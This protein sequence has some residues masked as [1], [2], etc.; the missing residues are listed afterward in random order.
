MKMQLA[1][2]LLLLAPLPAAA[3]PFAD[4]L[5]DE[6]LS[7]LRGGFTLPGGLQVGLG[8]TTESR[9]DGQLVLRSTFTLGAGAESLQVEARSSDGSLHRIDVPQAGSLTGPD[10]TLTVVRK[11][12]AAD[13]VLNGAQ[14]DLTHLAGSRAFG[15]I[16]A[17]SADGRTIDVNTLVSLDIRGA[18][19]DR[20]GSSL[21][22]VETLALDTTAGLVR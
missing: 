15:S 11:N 22:R 10:G 5:R 8:V 1:A 7:T 20:I 16:V 21:L 17:N 9:I 19:P 14:L 13:V 6:Q 12:G 18:T 2:M 3:A 4:P